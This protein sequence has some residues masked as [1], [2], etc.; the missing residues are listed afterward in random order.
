MG[1]NREK[2]NISIA[3]LGNLPFLRVTKIIL[4]F[5]GSNNIFA[6]YNYLPEITVVPANASPIN[7]ELHN[8]L[9][10]KKTQ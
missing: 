5:D 8:N 7:T 1:S 6:D 9:T 3:I 4:L 2:S 10:E